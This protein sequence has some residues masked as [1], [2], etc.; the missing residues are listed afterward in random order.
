MPPATEL[1]TPMSSPAPAAGTDA[2]RWQGRSIAALLLLEPLFGARPNTG[3][4][5]DEFEHV[6]AENMVVGENNSAAED[7]LLLYSFCTP[8]KCAWKRAFVQSSSHSR[9]RK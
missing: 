8:V 3:R 7:I 1:G 5:F 9:G 4:K 2:R 6:E